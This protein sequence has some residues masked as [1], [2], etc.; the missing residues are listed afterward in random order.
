MN[1]LDYQQPGESE[2]DYLA[3]MDAERDRDAWDSQD[4]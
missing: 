2:E 1:D 3:R 4:A